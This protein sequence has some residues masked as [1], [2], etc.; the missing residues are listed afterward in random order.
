MRRLPFWI[1]VAAVFKLHSISLMVDVAG[2]GSVATGG[3][4]SMGSMSG[5]LRGALNYINLTGTAANFDVSSSLLAGME[6]ITLQNHLPPIN[7]NSGNSSYCPFF[8]RMETL[9]LQ[10]MTVQ[11]GLARGAMNFSKTQ[12]SIFS[13]TVCLQN[14][15]AI[16]KLQNE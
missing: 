13:L 5:D 15:S 2:G 8:V 16:D 1:L 4:F 7:L 6:T 9:D 11:N 3:T 14:N 12:Q 10:N